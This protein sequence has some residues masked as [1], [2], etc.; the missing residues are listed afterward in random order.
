MTTATTFTV[1]EWIDYLGRATLLGW[2]D[3]RSGRPSPS[4]QQIIWSLGA[5]PC[6]QDHHAQCVLNAYHAGRSHAQR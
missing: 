4:A 2:H 6:E 3:Y 1:S 5:I